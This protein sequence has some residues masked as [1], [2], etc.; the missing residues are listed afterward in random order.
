[1]KFNLEEIDSMEYIDSLVLTK[2]DMEIYDI[3]A[4]YINVVEQLQEFRIARNKYI[5]GLHVRLTS[6]YKPRIESFTKR[7]IDPIGDGVIDYFDSEEH[8]NYFN[9]L[10]NELYSILSDAEIAYINDCLLCGKSENFI[11]D[12][13]EIGRKVFDIIKNSAIVRF[14]LVFNVIVYK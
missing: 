3:P 1:M 11:R 12:K 9:Y 7:K 14:G 5:G 10:L 8:Y 13:F 2:K 6:S 4:T